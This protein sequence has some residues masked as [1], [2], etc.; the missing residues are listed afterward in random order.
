MFEKE[1]EEYVNTHVAPPFSISEQDLY[2][3]FQR[4]VTFGYSKANKWHYPSKG[5]YPEENL[6]CLC[7]D[8]VWTGQTFTTILKCCDGVFIDNNGTSYDVIAWKEIVLPE[9]NFLDCHK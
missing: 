4:A 2:D 5:E 7:I 1:A 3:C 6:E 9:L 8:K